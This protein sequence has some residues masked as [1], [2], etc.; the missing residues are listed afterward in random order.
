MLSFIIVVVTFVNI[1][2]VMSVVMSYIIVNVP[3]VSV[4]WYGLYQ[5]SA[6]AYYIYGRFVALDSILFTFFDLL[7]KFVITCFNSFAN[8]AAVIFQYLNLM[9][10]LCCCYSSIISIP[11]TYVNCVVVI[12]KYLKL[13]CSVFWLYFSVRH[14]CEFLLYLYFSN[15]YLHELCCDYISIPDTYVNFPVIVL[16]SHIFELVVYLSTLTPVW[17]LLWL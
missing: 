16:L 6:A 2:T 17:I 10:T 11:C 8:L 15:L 9:W 5:W 1:V 12:F 3:F 7:Y 13:M 4:M 14:L